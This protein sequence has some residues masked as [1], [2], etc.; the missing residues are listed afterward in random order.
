M[1]KRL[2]GSLLLAAL[3]VLQSHA[4]EKNFLR[5]TQPGRQQN[6]VTTARQ[7]LVGSTCKSCQVFVNDEPQ[8]VYPTG[9]F[10]IELAL[11]EGANEFVVKSLGPD[12]D[13]AQRTVY[14]T[15]NEPQEPV[16]VS[17]VNIAYVQTFPEGNLLL[18]PGDLIRFR[19]K[20]IPGG[21]VTVG[22]QFKLMEL[23]VSGAQTMPG[24]YQGTYT[25]QCDD[26][27][28]TGRSLPVTLEAEGTEV[29]RNTAYTFML[30]DPQVQPMVGKTT[31]DN[32]FLKY[33]LG[34]DR[35]G[36]A[37]VGSL[38]TGVYLNINGKV[39][40]DYRVKLSKN[41][42]AYI[43]QEQVV[44]QAPGT[45]PPSS[46]SNSWR[47][48]GD[49]QFDYVTVALTQK[50]PYRTTQQTDPS[51]IVLD[52][53]GATANTN[54][55][56]QLE[57]TQEIKNAYYEQVEDD[58]LR[59]IVELKHKQHWGHQ[60]Y[61]NNNTLTLK[62][63]RPPSQP[64]LGNLTIAVDAGHGGRNLGA[65]GPTGVYEKEMALAV[66]VALQR[67]LQAE[68][69]RVLMTRVNDSYVDNNYRVVSYRDKD[70]D[71]LVSIHLNSSSDPV[72]IQGTS[73]YYKHIGFRPLSQY[74]YKHMLE[75]GL[76]EF[77]NVGSFNFALNSPTEYP[78]VLVET[79]FLSNPEDEMKVLD[80][81]FR[82]QMAGK[83]VLGI[84]DF[85]AAGYAGAEE[86]Q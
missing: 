44:M 29:R 53:Y 51:R 18:A 24:I 71:L 74:I 20:A 7:F 65:Q 85:V 83:I 49:E 40:S 4:Q 80:A 61:Y 5:L 43:P 60:V 67:A 34:E 46:L 75:L 69:A 33:G 84:K 6:S 23:P 62:V 26:P 38:D 86:Q 55:I 47:V 78:N 76:K 54:W 35:L 57:N 70:P 37:R 13:S 1:K 25:V 39:G 21:T 82:Q 17:S 77:G 59:V 22:G 56:T 36:G 8:K 58:I 42:T 63:K 14:F 28:I 9:A 3:F 73:T 45:F 30:R 50:L 72:R 15:F 16:P 68:G 52:I 81:D 48:W 2:G 10:A 64:G 31:G 27:M 19:V 12:G 79:L 41:F 32:P 11:E 66:A